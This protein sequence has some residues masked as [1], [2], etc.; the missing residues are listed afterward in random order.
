MAQSKFFIVLLTHFVSDLF[1][2]FHPELW[3]WLL[4]RLIMLQRGVLQLLQPQ[5]GV[6]LW[7]SIKHHKTCDWL[8]SRTARGTTHKVGL[9]AASCG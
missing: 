8:G 9:A 7:G 1:G 4:C 3:L 2:G 6:V 5:K